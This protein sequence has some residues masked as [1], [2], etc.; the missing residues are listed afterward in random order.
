MPES[1]HSLAGIADPGAALAAQAKARSSR[2]PKGSETHRP[3][4]ELPLAQKISRSGPND[5]KENAAYREN[6][7]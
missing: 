6:C 4:R 7:N 1:L 2:S 3:Q 5:A